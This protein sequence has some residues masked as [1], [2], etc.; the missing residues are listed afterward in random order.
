M[1][2]QARQMFDRSRRIFDKDLE[3]EF[4]G[5]SKC[6]VVIQS[7]ALLNYEFGNVQLNE[8]MTLSSICRYL[9]PMSIFE[10]GTFN[11]MTTL[12]LALNSPSHTQ[13]F[14][15]DLAP[16]DP[17]RQLMNDDTY[18]VQ[19]NIVGEVFQ[20]MSERV[21]INQILCDTTVF[22]H[23]EYKEKIDMIFIDA[24]HEYEFVRSDS[25]KALEMLKPGGV[26]LW[27]DYVFSHY[28]VYTLL[29]ELS[30]SIELFSIPNTTLVCHHSSTK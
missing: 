6:R 16:D 30:H 15:I 7:T 8:L 24:S 23:G 17:K 10:F 22:D 26:I 25:E 12:H 27:H 20:S 21:R 19:R 3:V 13:I 9:N 18:Y 29:N 5:I 1:R 2:K 11:G 14:T 4:P 28:G